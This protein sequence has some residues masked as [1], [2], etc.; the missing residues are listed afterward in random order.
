[1]EHLFVS[2]V[3]PSSFKLAWSAPEDVFDSFVI[4][5]TDE[6]TGTLKELTVAGDVRTQDIADLLEDTEFKITLIGVILERRF[7][8]LSGVA[9]TGISLLSAP[10]CWQADGD[11][12]RKTALNPTT[13]TATKL[14]NGVDG[15]D[16]CPVLSV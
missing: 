9:K 15:I 8:P 16:L 2:D 14:T 12:H 10:F 7:P 1:M 6:A 3:T 4:M 5:I 11:N 13:T